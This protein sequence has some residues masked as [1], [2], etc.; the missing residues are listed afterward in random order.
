MVAAMTAS[1]PL[2]ASNVLLGGR[3]LLLLP[4]LVG[5]VGLNEAIVLQQVRYRLGDDLRP[6]VRENRRWARDPLERWR[7]RDFPFWEIDTLRRAFQSLETRGLLR[8]AQFDKHLR[9]RT[10]SYTID[11]ELLAVREREY[12]AARAGQS[13]PRVR[14]AHRNEHGEASSPALPPLPA[15][16]LLIDESPLV[17]VVGL[18]TA[19][20]L[21]EAL[22]LQQI[23]YW[24]AD[25]R[26]PHVREGCRWVCPREVDLF[27]PLAFRSA[28]T[29]A[30][31]LRDL[32]RAGLLRAS[33]RF[34]GRSGDRTK[35]YTIDFARVAALKPGAIGQNATIEENNS[36]LSSGTE[37]NDQATQ[38]A[39]LQPAIPPVSSPPESTFQGDKLPASLMEPQTEF[40]TDRKQQHNS[41]PLRTAGDVVVAVDPRS[42]AMTTLIEQGITPTVA[43]TLAKD[44]GDRIARQV[45]IFTW[46]RECDADDPRLTPG[47]LRRMI[48]EDWA[49]PASF[50]P[51]GEREAQSAAM[52][53]EAVRVREQRVREAQFASADDMPLAD[54]KEALYARLGIRVA[55]Q[56][57][58]R[59]LLA[60]APGLPPFLREAL[61]YPPSSGTPVAAAIFPD[62]AHVQRANALPSALRQ[63]LERRLGEH[64]HLPFATIAFLD[65][66]TVLAQL[67]ADADDRTLGSGAT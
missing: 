36:P 37:C 8:A 47:R 13:A 12:R 21:D 53:A 22:I 6:L 61:F 45:E 55:D 48:E 52:S 65:Q 62:A 31:A 33:D 1:P 50:L 7:E 59:A 41:V 46:L 10:K 11:F 4:T 14:A 39:R 44:H 23:R 3:L 26:R 43:A 56:A 51:R 66:T 2:P 25:D 28:K 54:A 16:D 67:V 63:R 32:E 15:G 58:W 20:G 49:P 35:W 18:A 24:L 30:R 9:D 27:A 42:A 57:P 5:M 19:I 17:I 29:I 38:I 34:N 64:Y 40:E 60:R